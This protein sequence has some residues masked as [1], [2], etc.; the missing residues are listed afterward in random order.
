MQAYGYTALCMPLDLASQS[1]KYAEVFFTHP[2]DDLLREEVLIMASW[3][4]CGSCSTHNTLP[5]ETF[6]TQQAFVGNGLY[7]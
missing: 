4:V 2:L 5:L 1:F 7:R 6:N 3:Y